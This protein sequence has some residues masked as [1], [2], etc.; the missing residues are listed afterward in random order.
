M[1][2]MRGVSLEYPGASLLALTQDC[3]MRLWHSSKRTNVQRCDQPV[4]NCLCIS[5]SRHMVTHPAE[6]RNINTVT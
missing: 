3:P 6:E 5:L 4:T 1:S 2:S